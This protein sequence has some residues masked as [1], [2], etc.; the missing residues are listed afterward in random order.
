[1]P[2]GFGSQTLDRLIAHWSPQSPS[3]DWSTPACMY[4]I[5]SHSSRDTLQSAPE[6]CQASIIQPKH[7]HYIPYQVLVVRSLL[8]YDSILVR[9]TRAC[10][11]FG[12]LWLDI[13]LFH[14]TN[15]CKPPGVLFAACVV[16][17]THKWFNPAS[18]NK[19]YKTTINKVFGPGKR[20]YLKQAQVEGLGS[21]RQCFAWVHVIRSHQEHHWYQ[22]VRSHQLI[23]SNSTVHSNLD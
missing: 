18:W 9:L 17:P 16:N 22:F 19:N 23:I 1:M 2:G 3:G 7:I 4:Q 20:V 15:V 11:N 10:D 13:W 14:S 6:S 12:M 5:I 8:L 21:C